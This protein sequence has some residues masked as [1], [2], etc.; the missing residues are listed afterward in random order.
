MSGNRES[1]SSAE[2]ASF[3]RFI[4]SSVSRLV[5]ILDGLGEEELQWRPPAPEANSI[6]VLAMH[7]LGNLEENILQTLCGEPVHREHDE[8]FRADKISAQAVEDRWTSLRLRVESALAMLTTSDLD[9]P[10]MHPRRGEITGRDVLIVVARHT[11]EHLG[12]AE[13]TRDLMRAAQ[14]PVA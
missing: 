13:L 7:T 9:R 14:Q 5:S 8:E 10:R 4:S 1:F 12:Q 2:V 3:W 6:N 11:A